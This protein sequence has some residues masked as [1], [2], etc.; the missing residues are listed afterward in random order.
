MSALYQ[1]P[2]SITHLLVLLY[3]IM[4][5][6]HPGR[7]RRRME[8]RNQ[9]VLSNHSKYSGLESAAGTTTTSATADCN[10]IALLP[11]FNHT[12]PISY[13]ASIVTYL[14]V[15]HLKERNGLIIPEVDR[16]NARCGKYYMCR[17]T[18]FSSLRQHISLHEYKYPFCSYL[19]I[20]L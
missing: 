20:Y 11:L 14:A 6:A 5:D 7:N 13:I 16:I 17:S 10:L 1:Q 2:I 8:I 12:H 18:F 19:F 4:S 15:K 9:N 3:G